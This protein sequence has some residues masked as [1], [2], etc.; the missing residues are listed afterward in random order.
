[1]PLRHDRYKPSR[2]NK[3][4]TMNAITTHMLS[5]RSGALRLGLALLTLGLVGFEVHSQP[6]GIPL[7]SFW[8]T[9]GPVYAI[10]VNSNT[11]Y[12]GGLFSYVGPNT[13][14]AGVVDTANAAAKP[15]FPLVSGSVYSAAPDGNGG[16]YIGGNF[17][18][19][20]GIVRSNLAHILSNN[21]VDPAWNPT[22]N[23]SNVVIAVSGSTVYI[24]GAFTR[25][26]AATRNRIAAL[27]A[28]TGQPT[29]WNP[30]ASAVV[31]AIVPVGSLLYVG[32][33]F[34]T[35]GS[36]SRSR[37]AALDAATGLAT[38]WNPGASAG[39]VSTIAI[40]ETNVYVGGT[41]TTAGGKPR[42]RMAKLSTGSDSALN[43]IADA[44]GAVSAL[45]VFG[46]TV[47]AGGQFTS[48]GSDSRNWLAALDADSALATAWN[49]A[50]SA[51]INTLLLSGTNLLVGG[52]FNTIDSQPRTLLAAF[53]TTTGTLSAWNPALSGLLAGSAPQ[54]YAVAAAGSE[55]LA[56]GTVSSVGGVTRNNLAAFDTTTGRATAWDPN[57]GGLVSAMAIGPNSVY[58]G[59]TFTNIGGILRRRLA[60]VNATNG[61]VQAF[62]PNVLGRS[63]VGVFALVTDSANRLYVGGN[64]TN[65]AATPRGS[66]AI[67][68]SSG[69]LVALDPNAQG[70][71][72]TTASASV[73]ALLLAGNTLY[74]GGDFVNI[75]GQPRARI[76]ALDTATGAAT[77]WNPAASNAVTA[78]VLSGTNLYVGGSFTN[79]GGQLRSRLA[80]IS[81]NTGLATTWNP[82][83][84]VT[85][86]Q[87]RALATAGRSIYVGGQFTQVGG[88]FR[89]RLAGLS[90][91][92]GQAQSWNPD[93]N[94]MVR[95]IYRTLDALYV[96]GDFT[97][98]GGDTQT[99]FAVFPATTAFVPGSL[100]RQPNGDFTGSLISADGNRVII[101]ATTD[102]S[103]WSNVSTN[104]PDGFPINFTD[105]SASGFPYRFYRAVLETQ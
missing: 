8:R 25:V 32:G 40:S 76:A 90:L 29:A 44:N 85:T 53:D 87:I 37:I 20:G 97:A 42:Q 49:P 31:N 39:T 14:G 89:N 81:V 7:A 15:G 75:G 28:T 63:T 10:A 51:S 5:A 55:V 2:P 68:N 94:A 19:V 86:P 26:G 84:G 4:G 65:I 95:V 78:L 99:Y 64:F 30:N 6:S 79:I 100:Q 77:A 3:P 105:T 50:P 21:A 59:G 67:F 38:T 74:A 54:V 61:L 60:A 11:V 104:D 22:L 12:V 46:S 33:S 71:T 23:G 43:W 101:Q 88:E 98:I 41:F 34:T 56:G 83:A 70:A 82:N 1:M 52:G 47:Y 69:G 18:A 45:A 9:D 36:Q 27:D 93:A 103:S 62:D 72:P 96:G 66:I 91:N 13:G 92:N 80:A 57:A 102:F 24:G 35:I 17:W 58:V 48:I 16:W 73:N